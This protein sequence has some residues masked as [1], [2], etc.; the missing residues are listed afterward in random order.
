[1]VVRAAPGRRGAAGRGRGSIGRS[2][3]PRDRRPGRPQ[4]W[5]LEPQSA[6]L[7]CVGFTSG[8]LA[9]GPLRSWWALFDGRG[10][11]EKAR[12]GGREQALAWG[13]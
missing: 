5:G 13:P 8:L 12:T 4:G 11:A 6:R 1:M 3:C 2:L 10:V 9:R 7:F